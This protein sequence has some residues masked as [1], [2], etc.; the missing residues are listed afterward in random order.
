MKLGEIEIKRRN[1]VL[2]RIVDEGQHSFKELGS[3]DLAVKPK[4]LKKR[5][6]SANS[7]LFTYCK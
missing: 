1:K 6:H 4:Y 2:L 3:L 5:M 7:I